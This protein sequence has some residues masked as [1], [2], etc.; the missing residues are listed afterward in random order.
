MRPSL[1]LLRTRKK[2]AQLLNL[3]GRSRLLSQSDPRTVSSINGEDPLDFIQRIA[4]H[5]GNV[6]DRGQRINQLLMQG[7]HL[8]DGIGLIVGY[9][10]QIMLS[11]ESSVH[12]EFRDGSTETVDW[13]LA[14]NPAVVG[15]AFSSVNKDYAFLLEMEA[16]KVQWKIDREADCRKTPGCEPRGLAG[17]I[18]IPNVDMSTARAYR[19]LV[20]HLPQDLLQRAAL[21]SMQEVVTRAFSTKAEPHGA[22][23]AR[24]AT[25]AVAGAGAA[26]DLQK[27]TF[28]PPLFGLTFSSPGLGDAGDVG[29]EISRGQRLSCSLP[30]GVQVVASAGLEAELATAL[31]IGDMAVLKL[32][33]MGTKPTDMNDVLMTFAKLAKAAKE[34]GVKRLLVDIIG[35]SGGLVLLGELLQ[36]LVTKEYDPKESCGRYDKRVSSYWREWI[37][38]FGKGLNDSVENQ[39]RVYT[40]LA[41]T[42]PLEVVRW[43]A[44]WQFEYLLGIVKSS[45]KVLVNA[46]GKDSNVIVSESR[47]RTLLSRVKSAMTKRTL[48]RIVW[49][50]LAQRKFIPKAIYGVD[51]FGKEQ[52]WFPFTGGEICDKNTLKKFPHMSGL[53]EPRTQHWGGRLGNYSKRGIFCFCVHST[54]TGN[55]LK[56]LR[57]HRLINGS[58]YAM[59]ESVLD[60]PFEDVAMISDGLAGSAGSTFASK[61]MASG[62][63]TVFTYGGRGDPLGMDSSGYSGGNVLH[64]QEWWPLVASAAEF[65]MFLLPNS[66]WEQYSR[67]PL[68][69][70]RPEA[71]SSPMYPYAMPGASAF[72]SFNFNIMYLREYSDDTSLPRQFYRLPAHRHY[73]KWPKNLKYTCSNTNA[74]FSMYRLVHDEDWWAVRGSPQYLNNGWSETCIPEGSKQCCCD[75]ATCSVPGP[76]SWPLSLSFPPVGL[77]PDVAKARSILWIICALIAPIAVLTVSVAVMCKRSSRRRQLAPPPLGTPSHAPTAELV[78][79]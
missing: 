13:V 38:S 17:T 39:M 69:A 40:E 24:V 70:L 61:L 72:A 4:D 77:C 57:R 1:S 56:M 55:S 29:A 11:T 34:H 63:V 37:L 9:D 62:Y 50:A 35:N 6:H 79:S 48:L 52:G 65:G 44:R 23:A 32:T 26:R 74:L 33:S 59:L 42:E 2:T 45:N 18:P 19:R 15:E 73:S 16:R 43:Y 58:T 22:A 76:P 46:F 31:I 64:Y 51:D 7:L 28:G 54:A 75:R 60:H 10:T 47:V 12:I 3:A 14:M 27:R 25:T 53:L 30:A 36:S 68:D 8:P 78:S 71:D 67:R 5:L 20:G 49:S 41:E 21:L 66:S